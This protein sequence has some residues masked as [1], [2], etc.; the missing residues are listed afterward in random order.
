MI[1]YDEFLS[2]IENGKKK[3]GYLMAGLDEELIKECINKIINKNIDQNFRELNV[4]KF[5]GMSVTFDEIFNAC[6]TM[7][8]MSD[9]KVVIVYRSVFLNEKQDIKMIQKL[10]DYVKNLP[11][12]TIFIMY[13]LLKDKRDKIPKNKNIMTFDKSLELVYCDKIRKDRFIKKV[14]DIFK[15]KHALIGRTELMY[16]INKCGTNFT[17]IKSES[18]KIVS[19]CLNREIKKND[20]DKIV[21]SSEEDDIFDLVDLVSQ[22][23]IEMAEDVLKEILFKRDSHMLIL[24]AIERQFQRLYEIKIGLLNGKNVGYFEKE[25]R[26]SN[27][28]ILKLISLSK[29]FSKKKIEKILNLTLETEKRIKSTTLDKDMELEFLLLST[30]TIKA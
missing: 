30:V 6:E 17:I 15:E 7:P 1:N 14:S 13:T 25:F 16:F 8:F 22:G 4:I 29:R 2:E 12:F 26:L 23:K 9:K 11:S 5:D 24:S 3:N 27:F 21:S 10:K 19:Y 28:V 20:I 18:D